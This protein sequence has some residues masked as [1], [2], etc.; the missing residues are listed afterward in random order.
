ME[1]FWLIK[2]MYTWHPFTFEFLS[3]WKIP[4][5]LHFQFR[6]YTFIFHSIL[7]FLIFSTAFWYFTTLQS[8]WRVQENTIDAMLW[9]HS[10]SEHEQLKELIQDL[11]P[12]P[13][14][15][16]QG[17]GAALGAPRLST[18][19]RGGW[20][21]GWDCSRGTKSSSQGCWTLG[22]QGLKRAL[23]IYSPP[24]QGAGHT[25]WWT[26]AIS[27]CAAPEFSSRTFLWSCINHRVWLTSWAVL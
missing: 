25:Y 17:F 9:T 8:Q 5:Q 11:A 13:P 23:C 27:K 15:T 12:Q 14:K 22:M 1:F 19:G 6:G 24:W 16:Q 3:P 18:E 10:P 26:G 4:I 7:T 20:S 21:L 2:Q